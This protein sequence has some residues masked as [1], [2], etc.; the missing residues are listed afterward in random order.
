MPQKAIFKNAMEAPKFD[1][2]IPYEG[3]S[4]TVLS[5][6]TL[7]SMVKAADGY[8]FIVDNSELTNHFGT[9]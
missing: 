3:Q 5:A 6:G 1:T 2:A 8:E 7:T 4:V 9:L